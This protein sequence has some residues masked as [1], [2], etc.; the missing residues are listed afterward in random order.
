M[1]SKD[2]QT[3]YSPD[4]VPEDFVL[5]DPDHLGLSL[6]HKLYNHWLLRQRK[7]LSPFVVLNGGPLHRSSAG[8]SA[9]ARGKRKADYQE[10]NT[11]DEEVRS[12][13]REEGS[14]DGDEEQIAPSV[15]CGPRIGKGR[16]PQHSAQLDKHVKP[17]P[18]PS[19]VPSRKPELEKKTRPKAIPLPKSGKPR[20]PPSKKPA[21]SI[22]KASDPLTPI[23]RLDARK[24]AEN[25]NPKKRKPDEDLEST[26]S[27][28]V[29]KSDQVRKSGRRTVNVRIEEPA[30]VSNPKA[31]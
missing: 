11:D 2:D 31:N 10:V 14:D 21:N 23:E 26:R 29:L 7:K 4:C 15:K 24:S 3:I 25:S 9:K 27:P 28:K 8:L 12:E 13:A 5:S 1:A 17:V 30:K 16:K 6:I 20:E 22:P 18:G 19:K